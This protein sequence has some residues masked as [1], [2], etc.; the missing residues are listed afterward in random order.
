MLRRLLPLAGLVGMLLIPSQ[1]L[2]GTCPALA[3]GLVDKDSYRL[4]E[5]IDFFGT[6][7]DFADPGTVTITFVRPADGAKR[8]YTANNSPDGSW[9]LR[10]TLD[11]GRDIGHWTVT[12]IVDQTGAHDTCTDRVTIRSAFGM[13]GTATAEPATDRPGDGAWLPV[14]LLLGAAGGIA[15][16]RRRLSLP[17]SPG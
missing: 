4:G 8:E 13:P 11:S 15:A 16:I 9:Y 7:H 2:A 1:A 3:E 10:F 12:A 6:Y 17:S 14:V 5:L